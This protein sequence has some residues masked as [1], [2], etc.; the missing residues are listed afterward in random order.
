MGRGSATGGG[1]SKPWL[2]QP[3]AESERRDGEAE[4]REEIPATSLVGGLLPLGDDGFERPLRLRSR[5]PSSSATCVWTS[6]LEI[7]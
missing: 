3:G 1:W 2:P 4:G 7:N 5:G 6:E